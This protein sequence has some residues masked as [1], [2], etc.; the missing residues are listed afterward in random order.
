MKVMTTTKDRNVT[1]T[2][3]TTIMVEVRDKC[4]FQ[5]LIWGYGGGG[6]SYCVDNFIMRT[7]TK[8]A[9]TMLVQLRL[10]LIQQAYNF[11][12]DAPMTH[13]TGLH[14]F[15]I[16]LKQALA[17]N[18]ALCCLPDWPDYPTWRTSTKIPGTRCQIREI[19]FPIGLSFCF[20]KLFFFFVV[21]L[22]NVCSKASLRCGALP[23]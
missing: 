5:S 20:D 4:N 2:T 10:L 23:Y 16:D 7:I 22:K 3:M 14:L 21:N 18:V 9:L 11:G 12:A 8:T 19:D 6:G 1:L 13:S 17:G 15:L